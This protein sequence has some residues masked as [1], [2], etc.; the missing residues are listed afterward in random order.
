LNNYV[1][2]HRFFMSFMYIYG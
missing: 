1:V 2:S